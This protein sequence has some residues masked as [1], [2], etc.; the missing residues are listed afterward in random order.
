M[1]VFK[2]RQGEHGSHALTAVGLHFATGKKHSWHQDRSGHVRH[3]AVCT[4]CDN[5][6]HIVN[7]D[8]VRKI[9]NE[10]HSLPLYAKHPVGN[11]EE[12]GTFDPD[13]H[14]DCSLANPKSL[15]GLDKGR[16]PGKVAAGIIEVLR[17]HADAL[18][19]MVGRFLGADI[20]DDLFSSILRQGHKQE[21]YFY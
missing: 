14:E 20:S 21:G 19:Y 1:N 13:A 6:I 11:M 17:D 15:H 3:Y 9:D 2:L 4:E 7:L 5:P 10:G 18:H 8:V 16:R 12:I